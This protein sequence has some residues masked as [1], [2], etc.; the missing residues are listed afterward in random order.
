MA[1]IVDSTNGMG[2]TQRQL[3]PF[4]QARPSRASK[5]LLTMDDQG[6]ASEKGKKDIFNINGHEYTDGD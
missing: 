3:V 2:A 6:C 1:P 5:V 4:S